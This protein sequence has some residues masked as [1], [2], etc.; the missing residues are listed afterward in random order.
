MFIFHSYVGAIKTSFYSSHDRW[1][2]S[3]I[4]LECIHVYNMKMAMFRCK[5]SWDK[6]VL[7]S[8]KT[9]PIT[10]RGQ[11]LFALIQFTWLHPNGAYIRRKFN[12]C[13]KWIT[14]FNSCS[15]CAL[16]QRPVVESRNHKNSMPHAMAFPYVLMADWTLIQKES[17][18][19]SLCV[20][21][22]PVAPVFY[23]ENKSFYWKRSLKG[24]PYATTCNPSTTTLTL[25]LQAEEPCS[26]RWREGW[27]LRRWSPLWLPSCMALLFTHC[28]V[29]I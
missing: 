17:R 14:F 5:L 26:R 2:T 9:K 18:W 7:F 25:F 20:R 15:T 24:K 28:Q 6:A 1:G 22:D 13:K 11:Q 3:H 10:K 12:P 8:S 29:G 16:K 21:G 19:K 23:T 4:K 27:G